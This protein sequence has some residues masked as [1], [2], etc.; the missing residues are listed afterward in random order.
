M[1]LSEA[2][3][4]IYRSQV[5]DKLGEAEYSVRLL[6]E[7]GNRTEYLTPQKISDLWRESSKHEVLFS[8][9]TAGKVEPFLSM[10]FNPGSIWMEIFR[11]ET[12]TPVGVA[13]ITG[14]IPKFDAKGHFAF[15]DSVAKGR[16]PLIWGIMEW[17]FDRFELNRISAETPPYQSGVIR[18]IKRLGFQE[19]GTRR[20]AVIH[21]G[22]WMPLVEFGILREEFDSIERTV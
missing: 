21:K 1:Q 2:P 15:W 7:F 9:Y 22:R 10:F 8:D 17:L 20:G 19:E 16:E 5:E 18:F 12:E 4:E 14:V 11:E 3:L 6:H 13:Y